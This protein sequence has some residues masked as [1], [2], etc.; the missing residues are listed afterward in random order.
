MRSG[1]EVHQFAIGAS[2]GSAEFFEYEES[3]EL[4]S[5]HRPS[6]RAGL[7]PIT[8]RRSY[9]VQIRALDDLLPEMGWILHGLAYRVDVTRAKAQNEII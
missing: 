4:A 9:E 2:T 5:L 3:E 1:G 8:V 7:P 6:D